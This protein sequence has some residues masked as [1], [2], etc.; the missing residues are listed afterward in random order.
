[1]AQADG[2]QADRVYVESFLAEELGNSAYLIVSRETGEAALIDPLRDIEQYLARAEALGARITLALET[3]IHNDF[4]SG[5]REVVRETGAQLVASASAEL[6]YPY[7]ALGD[8]DTLMLGGWGLRAVASPGHT[9]EHVSY[10]LLDGQGQPHTLF[11]G[12]SLMVGGIARPDLLGPQHTA[13]LARAAYETAHDRLLILPDEVNVYPTHGA[14][15]FCGAGGANGDGGRTSTIGQERRFNPLLRATTYQQFLSRYL[16]LSAY[17]AY[18]QRMRPLNRRGA[19]LLGRSLPPLRPLT[20]EQVADATRAGAV[21]VDARLFEQ[22]DAAH[23]PNSLSVPIDGPLSAW[24]GWLLA[25]ETPLVLLAATLDDARE[26]QRELL[27][28]GFDNILGTLEGGVEV[29]R[30]AGYSTRSGTPITTAAVAAALTAGQEI[31]IVDSRDL[32]E[33]A[34]GHIPGAVWAPVAEIQERA[35]QLSPDAPTAVHCAHGYR[36][37]I[38]GSVLE[39]A[40]FTQV[41]HVTDGYD[42]WRRAWSA[43]ADGHMHEHPHEHPHEHA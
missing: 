27:R 9:P 11:S 15:S 17:P 2:V 5:A 43:E 37:S 13:A 4:I 28:I 25:L 8:G 18:Y 14:G 42:E 40:G 21:V 10:L 31:A 38:A 12:G 19:P 7:Q 33:W 24:V 29:W 26:A 36:S 6:E 32:E 39:R 23:I 41:L 16:Q 22:Y 35:R 20:P 34:A 3:H 30:T 1:M